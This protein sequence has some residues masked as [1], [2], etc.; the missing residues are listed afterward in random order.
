MT[1]ALVSSSTRY[2]SRTLRWR[3]AAAAGLIV[4]IAL[5]GGLWLR[6]RA[7]SPA[8]EVV[9]EPADRGPVVAV[10]TATGVV[11]PVKTVLVGTYV[12]GPIREIDVDFNTPV[13]RGQRMAKIDPGPFL[14]KV[15]QF[16]AAL[17]ST[18]ARVAKSH[19][20]LDRKQR[21]LA[22][23]IELS[24]RDLL[25][26]S[27]LDAA[28]SDV[29]QARAQLSLDE[30]G[31]RQADAGLEESRINLG[32]TDILSP[33]DGVVVSRNVDVGQ[34][35]AASFQ[36]PTLF[37]VAEDLTKMQVNAAVSESD[38][39]AVAET[40][41]AEFLVDAHPGR[42]FRGHVRQVRNAPTTVSNVV[43]YDVV[44]EVG[45]EDLALKPGMT[46]TVS[47][48]TA[49]REDVLRVPLRALRFRPA[50]AASTNT[51]SA[52]QTSDPTGEGDAV[53]ISDGTASLR[54]VSLK[55][56]LR[57]E[58]HVEVIDGALQAGDR[59]AVAYARSGADDE[60]AKTSPFMP[61]RRR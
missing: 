26:Q 12:S 60:P 56:G 28:R 13:R 10:V 21:D 4:A 1:D 11:N 46:A 14:M 18:R 22:R 2:G 51:S 37:Q 61:A 24:R 54:R 49:R 5:S 17:A 40:Q 29:A 36:T 50:E 8:G 44:I 33:V 3:L 16:E 31:V 38:I 57:D 32:Y 42:V 6:G 43:T 27:T 30:A 20:D 9:T 58:T 45:N 25:P 52:K 59:V 7:I 15:R 35:V 53:W 23:S 34:T 19:A 47:V 41:A 55:T 39:G 48:V